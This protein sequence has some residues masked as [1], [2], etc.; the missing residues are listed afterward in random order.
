MMDA[1]DIAADLTAAV[2]GLEEWLTEGAGSL[3]DRVRLFALLGALAGNGGTLNALR[4]ELE[5]SLVPDLAS[6][7]EPLEV[8][9]MLWRVT[10]RRSITG[11]RRD[12]L[13][14]A[15]NRL[16]L[17]PEPDPETGEAIAPDAPEAVDRM[18]RFVDVATG[19]TGKL[20]AAGID[21]DEYATVR[22][23]DAIERAE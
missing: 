6:E 9:G 23:M 14:S 21:P 8:D 12:E 4:H 20:A 13:R 1:S 10:R 15:V 3:S 2:T 22:W 5:Q 7:D 19:R 18:W 16:V 11:W 17:E